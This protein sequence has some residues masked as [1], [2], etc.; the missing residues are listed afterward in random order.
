MP[1]SINPDLIE[2]NDVE[3]QT[4]DGELALFHKPSGNTLIV[5][6]DTTVSE[7][8][9]S[10][11]RDNVDLDGNDLISGGSGEF[12][13][14]E[15]ES[16]DIGPTHIGVKDDAGLSDA[17][18][19][20]NYGDVI[21]LA[22][23]QYVNDYSIQEQVTIKG[24]RI[25][26]N[27]PRFEGTITV[28]STSNFVGVSFSGSLTVNADRCVITRCNP[29]S[30]TEINW[31]GNQGS[32]INSRG[33]SITFGSDTSRNIVDGCVLTSVT[34]NGTNTVGDIA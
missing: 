12:T 19:N 28:D 27:E 24:E 11:L 25:A 8:L 14:L 33:G 20:A 2:N 5:D 6:E 22:P 13:A 9:Q 23:N 29:F 17:L 30:T 21:V 32:F 31:F 15:A 3:I 7:K 18:N 26:A 1:F 34:D 4:V 10:P 16:I